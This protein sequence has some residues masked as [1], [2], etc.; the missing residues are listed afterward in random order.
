MTHGPSRRA[1]LLAAAAGALALPAICTGPAQAGTPLPP[2]HRE[3]PVVTHA[4]HPGAVRG[5]EAAR[6][7]HAEP[8]N[9]TVNCALQREGRS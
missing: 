3:L 4:R 1:T 8:L 9:A 5:P 6:G 2:G 7:T